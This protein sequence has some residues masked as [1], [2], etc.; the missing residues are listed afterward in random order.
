M[1]GNDPG[2]AGRRRLVIEKHIPTA[3]N[4][5][6]NETRSEPGPCWQLMYG[7]IGRKFLSRADPDNL[8]TV[9]ED[10]AMM[11]RNMAVEDRVR[12]NCVSSEPVHVVRV[13]L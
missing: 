7:D 12:C 3:V 10:G 2:Y 1:S 8:G 5:H 11:M 13:I 4:L 9:D 6:V